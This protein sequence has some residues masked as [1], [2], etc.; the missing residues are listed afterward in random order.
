MQTVWKLVAAITYVIFMIP[1]IAPLL[2]VFLL[3][4]RDTWWLAA[5]RLGLFVLFVVIAA[6]WEATGG[7]FVRTLFRNRIPDDFFPP[8][9][10]IKPPDH[11]TIWQRIAANLFLLSIVVAAALFVFDAIDLEAW[12]KWLEDKELPRGFQ[13]LPERIKYCLGFPITIKAFA[14]AIA[15]GCIVGLAIQLAAPLEWF[16]RDRT[17]SAR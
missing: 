12:V 2:F 11:V 1:V 17:G 10:K 16:E 13:R 4:P 3:P 8:I 6:N 15:G 5:A 14:I 7:K 9:P